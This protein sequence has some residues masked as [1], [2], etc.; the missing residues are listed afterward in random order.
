MQKITFIGLD[1]ISCHIASNLARAGY[2]VKGWNPILDCPFVRQAAA[3]EV[4]VLPNLED[5]LDNAD[6]ILIYVDHLRTLESILFRK[7]SI[8]DKVK[9]N[10]LV[11]NLTTISQTEAREIAQQLNLRGL[12]FINAPF[13]GNEIDANSANLTFFVQGKMSDLNECYSL[14][15]TISESV[16]YDGSLGA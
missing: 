6:Y 4:D 12:R 8:I 14:F 2:F 1:S 11:I 5:V 16:I 7:G 9:I 3:A 15:Q 13:S 10:T